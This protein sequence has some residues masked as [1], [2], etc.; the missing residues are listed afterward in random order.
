MKRNYKYLLK[1]IGLLTLS[2][3]GTK[4]LLFL[5]LPLYTSI[6]TVEEYGLYD[7]INTTIILL[8]P[9]LTFNISE[10]VIRFLLE[11]E[12]NEKAVFRIGAKY[13]LLAISFLSV[14]SLAGY[15]AGLLQEKTSHL[16]YFIALFAGQLLYN[17]LISFARGMEKVFEMAL[18]G[19]LNTLSTCVLNILFL[20]VFHWGLDG[21]F[22]A[23]I[24]GTFIPIIY[25]AAVLNVPSLARGKNK[26]KEL[27]MEMR[28][29]SSPLIFNSIGWWL[30]NSFDRFSITFMCGISDNGVFAAASKLPQIMNVISG[31]FSQAWTLSAVKEF[32]RKDSQYF[33]SDTYR[34]YSCIMVILCSVLISTN[35]YVSLF[36]FQKDFYEAWKYVPWL[37]LASVFS[38]LSSFL[39]GIFSAVKDSKTIAVST[40][41]SAGVNI[42]M[43]IVFIYF[44]GVAGAAAATALSYFS[45]WAIRIVL[46]KRYIILRFNLRWDLLAYGFL[47]I[48]IITGY[49]TKN[50]FPHICIMAAELCI[51]RNIVKKFFGKIAETDR[52]RI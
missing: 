39:G 2:N 35:R 7:F 34:M 10:A 46:V 16:G 36:L 26:S 41:E 8:I 32:D 48:Q 44:F 38:S 9:V 21:Y 12:N 22:L 28:D 50:F 13:S 1:N 18:A 49:M 3:F 40:M 42:V 15:L 5:L 19:G 29:Y 43:N 27:E 11:K 47:V 6:L 31:I 30:N 20:V 45:L 33:F 51:Y 37:L 23:T 4:I 52:R 24:L 14:C 25:L 17:F